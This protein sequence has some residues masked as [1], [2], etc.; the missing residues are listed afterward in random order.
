MA[1]F[2]VSLNYWLGGT[3]GGSEGA[4]VGEDASSFE[5][6]SLKLNVRWLVCVCA[7]VRDVHVCA[8]GDRDA[9]YAKLEE[10]TWGGGSWGG[11]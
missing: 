2:F 5:S 1:Y 9:V 11:E 3:Q 10:R 8:G 4:W 7:H 6:I